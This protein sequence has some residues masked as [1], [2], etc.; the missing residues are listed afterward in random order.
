MKDRISNSSPKP[1]VSLPFHRS[2]GR[3]SDAPA[4]FFLEEADHEFAALCFVAAVAIIPVF[5]V[6][7]I[8]FFAMALLS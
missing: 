8:V 7:A 4:S 5:F 6:F 2:T 3:G 1:M